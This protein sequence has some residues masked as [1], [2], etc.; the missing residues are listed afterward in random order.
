MDS[1][2]LLL[3]VILAV[4]IIYSCCMKKASMSEDGS[5]SYEGSF[6]LNSIDKNVFPNCYYPNR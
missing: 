1:C 2:V 6:A 3:V 4:I 5:C